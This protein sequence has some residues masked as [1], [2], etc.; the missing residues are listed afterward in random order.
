MGLRKCLKFYKTRKNE[1]INDLGYGG[2]SN[3]AISV[4][5]L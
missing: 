5:F 4:N 1:K 3:T 2:P